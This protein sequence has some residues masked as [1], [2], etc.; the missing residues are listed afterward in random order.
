MIDDGEW[1]EFPDGKYSP[2]GYNETMAHEYFPLTKKE[3][4]ERWYKRRDEP[5]KE[6]TKQTYI[7]PDSIDAVSDEIVNQ[8]LQC[9]V[10]KKNYKIIP[11]ELQFYRKMK[12][13]IPRLHPDQRHMERLKKRTP[14]HLR[15][16]QCSKCC[17]TIK[18]TY[19]PERSEKVY[20]EACYNKEIYS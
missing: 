11:Q 20:C 7:I 12:L 2:F 1:W 13:P 8:V 9:E 5:Q 15:E 16:R 4:L 10:S 19:A 14:R 17:A 6:F 18:T 3:A